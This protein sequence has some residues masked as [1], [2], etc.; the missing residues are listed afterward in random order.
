MVAVKHDVVWLL[1]A[2]RADDADVV[3][4]RQRLVGAVGEPDEVHRVRHHVQ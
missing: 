1:D 4:K 3:E 2:M